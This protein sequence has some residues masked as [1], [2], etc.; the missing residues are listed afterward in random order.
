MI[1]SFTQRN[2]RPVNSESTIPSNFDYIVVF[3]APMGWRRKRNVSWSKTEN[4]FR[5]QREIF[6]WSKSHVFVFFNQICYFNRIEKC[7]IY[8]NEYNNKNQ[9]PNPHSYIIIEYF[10]NYSTQFINYSCIYLCRRHSCKAKVFGRLV[11]LSFG[12]VSHVLV[13]RRF[14]GCVV[15]LFCFILW[16]RTT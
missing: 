12:Y 7:A 16:R 9:K 10:N 6:P 5:D 11:V 8:N 15:C 2:F 4:H 1:Q 3:R 13:P 14:L